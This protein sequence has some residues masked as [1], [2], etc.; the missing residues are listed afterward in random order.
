MV[1]PDRTK[2]G[3]RKHYL[4]RQP[5][6]PPADPELSS[7]PR[8]ASALSGGPVDIQTLSL[9][10]IK[11]IAPSKQPSSNK[12]QKQSSIDGHASLQKCKTPT[13][14]QSHLQKVNSKGDF[15][16]LAGHPCLHGHIFFAKKQKAPGRPPLPNIATI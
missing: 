4:L 1:G 3:C 14:P 2:P 15:S 5:G 8:G 12:L 16:L 10:L 7:A 11:I 9:F 6:H 13:K